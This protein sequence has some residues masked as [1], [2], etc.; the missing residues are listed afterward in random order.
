M[1]IIETDDP[2]E[3]Q[4]CRRVQYH[5]HPTAITLRGSK[6]VG[7]IKSVKEEAGPRW[8]ITIVPKETKAFARPRHR[9]SYAV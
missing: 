6:Y 1:Q 7:V 5:G 2:V 8:I 4:R 3:A 9:P